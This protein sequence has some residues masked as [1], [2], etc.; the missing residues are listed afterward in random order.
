M[1][2]LI[3]FTGSVITYTCIDDDDISTVWNHK[4]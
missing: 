3:S 1:N 4:I 2:K